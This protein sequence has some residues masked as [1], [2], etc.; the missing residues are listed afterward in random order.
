M[1]MKRQISL[2]YKHIP[3]EDQDERL[4]E[5]YRMLFEEIAKQITD[6]PSLLISHKSYDTQHA[7]Y[8]PHCAPSYKNI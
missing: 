1:Y 5:V 4:Y 6:E 7:G 2:I 3:L 8:K